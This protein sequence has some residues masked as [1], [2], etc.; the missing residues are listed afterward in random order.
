MTER[1]QVSTRHD[2]RGVVRSA[3]GLGAVRIFDHLVLLG[4][5]LLVA[6]LIGPD[7]FGA[8]AVALLIVTVVDSLTE[9][10]LASAVIH[11]P[12]RERAEAQTFYFVSIVRGLVLTT[13]LLA[14]APWI[15]AWFDA[16]AAA[17][18]LRIM[19]LVLL[20]RGLV[21]PGIVLRERD[22]DFGPTVLMGVLRA[23]GGLIVTVLLVAAVPSAS[24]LA[25]GIAAGELLAALASHL[26]APFPNWP[27]LD[28]HR[29]RELL[30]YGRWVTLSS[31]ALVLQLQLDDLSVGVLLG[32]AEL[33]EYQLAYLLACA[34][35]V[36]VAL[37]VNRVVFPSLTQLRDLPERMARAFFR[38]VELVA[39]AAG[40]FAGAL[41]VAGDRIVQ[42]LLGS[43][44]DGAV[45]AMRIL[46]VWGLL[47]AVGASTTPVLRAIG[48][49]DIVAKYHWAMVASTA[50]VLIPATD[51]WGIEG[52]AAAVLVPSLAV[53]AIRYRAIM[54]ALGRPVSELLSALT[55]AAVIGLAFVVGAALVRVF[56]PIGG[57]DP[58]LLAIEL[59]GGAI[60]AAA[61]A[62]LLPAGVRTRVVGSVR[63]VLESRSKP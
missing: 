27:S 58:M 49:P 16:P 59:A 34:P 6:R 40:I 13:F 55:P 12:R 8:V 31:I 25:I 17:G 45:A 41:I 14:T 50:V 57:G 28:V 29:L 1:A 3:A 48:R 24:A 39:L 61:A 56:G 54:T 5:R 22:V 26:L 30:R 35:A 63:L 23:V 36:E 42:I 46:A 11:S 32:S 43:G 21:S 53:S 44:W 51:R 52:A 4:T 33:A 20:A 60:A 47:R 2:S 18:P 10:G 19:A 7:D 9:T 62:V 38:T 37:V 15:V